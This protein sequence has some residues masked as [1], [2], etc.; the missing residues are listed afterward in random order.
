MK[1]YQLVFILQLSLTMKDK[2]FTFVL[3]MGQLNPCL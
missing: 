1:A 3:E 2:L